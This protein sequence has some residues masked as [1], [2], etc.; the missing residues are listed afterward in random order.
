[1]N[2]DQFLDRTW[3]KD[4]TCNE[5]S[6]EVWQ[7][8]TGENLKERLTSFLN[9]TGSFTQLSA[10]ESPC[11]ALFLR[12]NADSHVGIF[13]EGKLLHLTQKGAHYVHLEIMQ[14]GFQQPR[15]YK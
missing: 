11:I 8:I 2:L 12:K 13:F 7:H 10:P 5:F 4:Y 9:G 14:G 15:F 3:S 1:M 6:C